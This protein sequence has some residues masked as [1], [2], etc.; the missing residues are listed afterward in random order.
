MKKNFRLF[1]YTS[2]FKA[3]ET[4]YKLITVCTTSNA[5]AKNICHLGLATMLKKY[6]TY[7]LSNAIN[8][9]SLEKKLAFEN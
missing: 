9:K 8:I 3:G 7:L 5:C 6:I 1:P 2:L 4:F